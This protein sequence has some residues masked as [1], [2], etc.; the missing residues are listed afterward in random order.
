MSLNQFSRRLL[1]YLFRGILLAVPLAVTIYV[2]YSVFVTVDHV[3]PS[4]VFGRQIPGLGI[5]TLLVTFVLL[6]WLGGTFLAQPFII[7]FNRLLDTI[8]LVKTLYNS[9]KDFLS[10]FVGQ[11]KSFNVP[12]L[13]RLKD[14]TEIEQ[15]GFIT[16]EDLSALGISSEKVAVYIPMSY[17]IAGHVYIIPRKNVTII[18]ARAPEV[19][20]FIVSGGVTKIETSN[21]HDEQAS[22]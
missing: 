19:M 1:G 15:M 7:Y 17:S 14:N 11:K 12:V 8:P 5:L 16:A 10:A 3:V 13:V 20:K 18:D 6:G 22:N 21:E 9:I 2:L 4:E